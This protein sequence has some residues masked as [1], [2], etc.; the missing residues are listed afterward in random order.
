MSG[1]R[2]HRARGSLSR[3]GRGGRGRGGYGARGPPPD[4]RDYGGPSMG[5]SEKLPPPAPTGPAAPAPVQAGRAAPTLQAGKDEFGRDL[6]PDRPTDESKPEEGGGEE[7]MAID[8]SDEENDPV[9]PGPTVPSQ[10][11]S[12]PQPIPLPVQGT[13]P[14]TLDPGSLPIPI[15]PTFPQPVIPISSQSTLATFDMSVFNPADSTCWVSLAQAFHGSTGREPNQMELMQFLA[16]GE[17]PGS[18]DDGMGREAG[19]NFGGF[20]GGH[21]D[22]RGRGG[23]RARGRGRGRGAA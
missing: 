18:S 1:N 20:D 8:V 9:Q 5:D 15:P 16:T 23:Y 7:D 21:G 3:G 11:K 12:P 22:G 4:E 14:F 19:M 6:L 13:A 2:G 17:V 10:T